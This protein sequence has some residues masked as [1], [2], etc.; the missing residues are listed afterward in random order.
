MIDKH[1]YI[2]LEGWISVICNIFLFGI[3]YWAGISTGSVAI[4]ADAWHTLTDSV[5]SIIIIISNRISKKP[6]DEKHPYGH[7]RIEHIAALIIAMLLFVVAFDFILSGI[8][9]LQTKQPVIFGTLAYL[10]TILSIIIKEAMAQY[11]LWAY[12]KTKASVLKADAWHHRTDSLS[13]IIILIGMLLGNLFWWIDGVLALLVATMIAKVGYDILIEE[14]RALIGEDISKELEQDIKIALTKHMEID[15]YIHNM[16]LHKYG[17]YYEMSCHIKLDS[18]MS[19]NQVH[20]ICTK[21]EGILEK[22]FSIFATIH[23]EPIK[24]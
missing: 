22:Q 15:V 21:V 7:G 16:H 12:R 2:K 1:R 20:N 19:L 24:K 17:D 13:S 8:E 3:K 4:I 6:A 9:K 10:I 14:V 5:S 11:A 23:P 18:E